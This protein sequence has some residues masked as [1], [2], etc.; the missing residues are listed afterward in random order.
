MSLIHFFWLVS[1]VA[2]RMSLSH[3]EY[4]KLFGILLTNS[5]KDV[6]VVDDA[7]VMMIMMLIMTMVMMM[8]ERILIK[9]KSNFISLYFAAKSL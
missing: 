6:V 9:F 8:R 2:T 1:W 7:M 4:T 5:S 3:S